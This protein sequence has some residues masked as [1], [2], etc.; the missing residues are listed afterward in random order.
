MGGWGG[1]KESRIVIIVRIIIAFI[2][3]SLLSSAWT[4]PSNITKRRTQCK[5]VT[6]FHHVVVVVVVGISSN[7]AALTRFCRIA[8]KWTEREG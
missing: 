5:S 2:N 8:S 1:P 7:L 6:A 3:I 4:P